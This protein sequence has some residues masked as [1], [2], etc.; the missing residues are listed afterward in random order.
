MPLALAAP[1]DVYSIIEGRE[2]P[3][4]SG[5]ERQRATDLHACRVCCDIRHKPD[6]RRV[7][8]AKP[9]DDGPRRDH[10]RSL[11]SMML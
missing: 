3:L 4:C 5:C 2:S 8:T 1:R 6:K 11:P 7:V 10:R 9:R